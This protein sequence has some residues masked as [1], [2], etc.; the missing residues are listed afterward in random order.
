MTKSAKEIFMASSAIA[1]RRATLRSATRKISTVR[2]VKRT[3]TS[4]RAK[5][6]GPE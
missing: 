2:A 4:R 6:C 5:R 1:F 3:S